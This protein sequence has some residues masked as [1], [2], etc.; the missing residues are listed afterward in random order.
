MPKYIVVFMSLVAFGGA[1]HA[2][3]WTKFLS[4]ASGVGNMTVDRSS[5][6]PDSMQ[7]VITGRDAVNMITYGI[8]GNSQELPPNL[9]LYDDGN[10][11]VIS[12]LTMTSNFN[13]MEPDQYLT[14][15]VEGADNMATLKY[16]SGSEVDPQA[17]Y[18]FYNCSR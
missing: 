3:Q 16:R 5:D 9:H 17:N 6:Q 11:L 8:Q 13:P 2:D 1:A 14:Y 7:I 12:D 4:C 15:V 18:R 10:K